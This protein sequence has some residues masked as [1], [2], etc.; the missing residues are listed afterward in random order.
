MP[1]NRATTLTNA[2]VVLAKF[3]RSFDRSFE[4]VAL[5]ISNCVSGFVAGKTPKSVEEEEVEGEEV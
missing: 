1:L 2:K 3:V 4:N 5:K